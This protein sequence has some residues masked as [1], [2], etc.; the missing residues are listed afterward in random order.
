M[1]VE[2]TRKW[3]GLP[4][5][6]W[7][8]GGLVIAYLAYRWYS[9]RSSSGSSALGGVTQ[10]PTDTPALTGGGSS[11]PPP[12]TET[13]TAVDPTTGNAVDSGPSNT[14]YGGSPDSSAAVVTPLDPNQWY[15]PNSGAALGGPSP[16]YAYTSIGGQQ[17][18][19][20][21]SPGLGSA[22]SIDQPASVGY[23]NL[24]FEPSDNITFVPT[25]I[26]PANAAPVAVP[27]KGT[28]LSVV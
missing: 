10:S 17:T 1:T 6:T 24:G 3:H 9:H 16:L 14:D 18:L 12:F 23:E 26:N 5:W 28:R 2:L 15:G 4:V 19:I 11:A 22:F 7:G 13:T 20:G 8:I 27:V 21:Q 25:P